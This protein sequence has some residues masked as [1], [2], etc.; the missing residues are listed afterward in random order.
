MAYEDKLDRD[1]ADAS[2][3]WAGGAG[4][5]AAGD[6]WPTG[7]HWPGRERGQAA[8][9]PPAEDHWPAG[10]YWPGLAAG[11]RR[12]GD[13]GPGDQDDAVYDYEDGQP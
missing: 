12:L 6:C 2:G 1:G 10:D 5:L 9:S 13:A 7:G 4:V 11:G 3:P 8:D